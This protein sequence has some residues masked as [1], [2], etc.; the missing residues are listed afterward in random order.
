MSL[1]TVE[2]IGDK[3]LKAAFKKS[4]QVVASA[5]VDGIKKAA[6]TVE[7]RAKGHAP[8]QYG[9]LRGSIHT[10]GPFVTHDNVFAKVGTDLNYAR[11]QEEGTGIYGP[12]KQ[13]IKPKRGKFLVFKKG[14]KLIFAK[15]VRGVQGAGYFRKA[16]E[17]SIPKMVD[18]MQ[19]ALQKI[20]T[21]LAT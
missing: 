18:F 3:E 20:V 13:E 17:E 10:D 2:V 16:K 14:G 4:P 12:R 8:V 5:F 9:S 1:M 21:V 11:H 15:A 19:E 7:A 6:F